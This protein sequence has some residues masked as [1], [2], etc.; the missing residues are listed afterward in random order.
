VQ[1]EV[2]TG[3]VCAGEGMDDAPRVS[4]Q[5]DFAAFFSDSNLFDGWSCGRGA[6]REYARI[7]P[8]FESLKYRKS[9]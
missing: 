2:W 7:L 3:E 1:G 9:L 6:L 8:P 5:S 4:L